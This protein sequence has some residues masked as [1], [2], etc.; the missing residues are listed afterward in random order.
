MNKELLIGSRNTLFHGEH[1]VRE[2]T[3]LNSGQLGMGVAERRAIFNVYCEGENDEKFIVEIQNAYKQFFEECSIYYSTFLIW[4]A[5]KSGIW[6]FELVAV[7]TV[8]ILNFV[9]DGDCDSKDYFH[10]EIK[11]MDVT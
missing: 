3:Y 7:Y 8:G 1:I 11:L 2:V 4:E 9:F 10:R 5:S 6:N